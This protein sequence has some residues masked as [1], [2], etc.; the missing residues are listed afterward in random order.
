MA[1]QDLRTFL[2]EA[3]QAVPL[4]IDEY[5]VVRS[6]FGEPL[7]LVKCKTVDLEV[8][9]SAEMVLEGTVSLDE[10]RPKAPFGEYTT[11]YGMQRENPV[12]TIT[13]VTHRR[14]PIYFDCFSGHLDQ[15]LLGGTPRLSVIYKNVRATC[16]T[17]K[18]LYMPPNSTSQW[19]FRS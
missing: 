6:L 13:A 15:Q 8:P 5:D 2:E 11:L 10:I 3:R 7:Q 14:D 17:V 4:G 18:D 9:A 16:P 1:N 19:S 12:V